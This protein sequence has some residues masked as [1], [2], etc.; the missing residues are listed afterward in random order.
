MIPKS[1]ALTSVVV[2]CAVALL[3]AGCGSSKK[4][5]TPT[6]SASTPTSTVPATPLAG[7]TASQIKIGMW[8]VDSEGSCAKIHVTSGSAGCGAGDETEF[9]NM[10]AYV[11]AHGG[12]AGRQIVP[13]IYHTG[14]GVTFA[15]GAQQACTYFTQDNPV[16]IVIT[17]N[18]VPGN[19]ISCLV[20]HHVITIHADTFPYDNADYTSYFPYSYAPDRPRPE[21][22]VKAYVDGLA[23]A[24]FFSGN[25]KVGLVR[26][27]FPEYNS[28]F[29]SVMLPELQANNVTLAQDASIAPPASFTALGGLQ[30]QLSTTILKFKSAGINRVLF[31]TDV[32][33]LDL[34]W[35]SIAK[36]QN[37]FPQ[38]GLSST[39]QMS[40]FVDMA[41]KGTLTNAVGVGWDP[42]YDVKPAQDPGGTAATATCKQAMNNPSGTPV[43]RNNKCDSLLFVQTVLDKASASNNL[44]VQGFQQAAAALGTSFQPAEVFSDQFGPGLYDGPSSYR[45]Y[46]FATACN[47]FQYTGPLTPMSEV[48]VPGLP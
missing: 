24:H 44:T 42:F 27:D 8:W 30:T 36:A 47:C 41:P 23:S 13:V 5:T 34:F 38:Y 14:L 35:Y 33:T 32:G 39:E 1:K 37:Y 20:Q 11:N 48:P 4:S 25:V 22:W 9:K 19:S 15:Q 21:R 43:G 3:A 17:Q 28:V 45:V 12:I 46:S 29:N 2:V 18:A 6:T 10:T 16:G 31:L 7:M 26:Y 40:V